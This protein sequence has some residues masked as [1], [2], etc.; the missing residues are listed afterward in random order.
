ME[1]NEAIAIVKKATGRD[2]KCYYDDNTRFIF[3]IAELGELIN[4]VQVDKRTKEL[5]VFRP[6]EDDTSDI[7]G[8]PNKSFT[9]L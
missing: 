7:F 9:A 5:N 8:N 6:W 1:L 3:G 4:P 2:P